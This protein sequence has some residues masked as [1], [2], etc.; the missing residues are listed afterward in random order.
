MRKE[1]GD[2]SE[3]TGKRGKKVVSTVEKKNEK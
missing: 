1:S 2:A 3:K